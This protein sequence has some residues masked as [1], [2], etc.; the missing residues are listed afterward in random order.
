ML[1]RDS[2]LLL[3]TAFQ[4]LVKYISGNNNGN[5][6]SSFS[7]FV[8]SSIFSSSPLSTLSAYIGFVGVAG[9]G[10]IGNNNSDNNGNN[11]SDGDSN[12][13]NDGNNDGDGDS[14][15]IVFCLF[16]ATFTFLFTFF[17]GGCKAIKASIN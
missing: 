5:P 4:T 1:R 8:N 13:D 11:N 2:F 14:T 12:S 10:K 6:T 7:T 16:F 15:G 17:L 9:N 3:I